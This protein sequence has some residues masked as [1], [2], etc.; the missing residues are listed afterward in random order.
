MFYLLFF[1]FTYTGVQH[2]CHIRCRLK[3]N[4]NLGVKHHF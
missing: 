2:D 4:G 1:L 3:N